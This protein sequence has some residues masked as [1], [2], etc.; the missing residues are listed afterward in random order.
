M[1]K[2]SHGSF[3]CCSLSKRLKLYWLSVDLNLFQTNWPTQSK[4]CGIVWSLKTNK[5][6]LLERFAS[7]Y[8]VCGVQ[9][10]ALLPG[11]NFLWHGPN[12]NPIQL[13]IFLLTLV[14]VVLATS[15]LS[16]EHCYSKC[17][18][19]RLR[20]GILVSP[21]ETLGPGMG[22]TLLIPPFLLCWQVCCAKVLKNLKSYFDTVVGNREKYKLPVRLKY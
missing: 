12:L 14:S 10:S 21:H 15:E 13:N 8:S 16:S 11:I 5:Q 19:P 4:A 1:E 22:F 9:T 7:S 17:L 18:T 3:L 20:H 2:W 6:Q